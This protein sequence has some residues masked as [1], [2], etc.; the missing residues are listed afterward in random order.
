MI[1]SSNQNAPQRAGQYIQRIEEAIYD[2]LRISYKGSLIDQKISQL[3]K[4]AEN[5]HHLERK[6]ERS[7]S[8]P[9][10]RNHSDFS[11]LSSFASQDLHEK[12]PFD[13]AGCLASRPS[14]REIRDRM[15]RI[16]RIEKQLADN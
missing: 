3:T 5:T 4:D 6:S 11:T 2:K 12:K 13:S 8:K 15:A 9:H 1:F 14:A 10:S 7:S 16:K